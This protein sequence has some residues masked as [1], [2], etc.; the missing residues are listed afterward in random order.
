MQIVHFER[1]Q[2]PTTP[3]IERVFETVRGALS[4]RWTPKVV[5]CPTP[6]HSVFWLL[7]GVARA[8]SEKGDIYH[9]VG[10]IHY[11]ALG[12]PKSRSI[13]TVHDL[14]HLNR[15]NGLKK[16]LYRLLYFS[17]PLRQCAVITAISE[18]TREQIVKQFPFTSDKIVVIADPIPRGY[19]PRPKVFNAEWPR[20]LQ[21]GTMPHKNVGRLVQATKGL[22]CKLHIIGQLSDE[23]QRLL[24]RNEVDYDN[25]VNISDTEMLQA[26]DQADLVVFISL[27][28]GFGMPIIEAQA[29]G[30]PVIVSNCSPMKDVAGA[31][32]LTVNPTDI[33]AIRSAICQ[34]VDD[35]EMRQRIVA[36]GFDNVKRF[37][38]NVVAEQY[39]QLYFRIL[40][41]T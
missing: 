4:T 13:L 36:A 24:K 5:H 28:E 3:S 1:Q 30:R 25:S 18:T 11:T 40:R 20:I 35:G 34:V 15:L 16:I 7:K 31:G 17:I 27:S 2:T 33:E 26:Y 23:L 8:W 39:A 12:L 14:N 6:H 21:V 29:T 38:A 10:D 9:I 19:E 32:A 22:R 41:N 37:S